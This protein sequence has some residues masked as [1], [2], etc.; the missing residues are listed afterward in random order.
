MKNMLRDFNEKFGRED[1]FKPAIGNESLHQD[2]NDSSVRIANFVISKNLVLRRTTFRHRNFHEHT[3]YITLS[4][5]YNSLTNILLSELTRH[6]EEIIGDYH[7][8]FRNN[9]S[10]IDSK[11][12]IRQI[13]EEN[14]SKMKQCNCYLYTS[15]KL[16]FRS[17]RRSCKIYLLSFVSPL[18]WLGKK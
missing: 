6:A 11:I 4:T 15:R 16:L 10:T 3:R 8:G 14:G 12:C 17:G 7:C 18:Y 13:L 5:T 1:I 2:S 9:R